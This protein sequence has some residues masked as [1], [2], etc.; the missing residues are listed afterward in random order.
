MGLETFEYVDDLVTTNPLGADQQSA[1]DDHLRGLKTTIK[2]TLKN[3]DGILVNWE[4]TAAPTANDDSGSGYVQGSLWFERDAGALYLCTDATATAAVW[5]K[6]YQFGTKTKSVSLRV[7][8]S[9]TACSTGDDQASIY[10][11]ADMDGWNLTDIEIFCD[12]AGT[13]G[14]MDV[15]IHNVD[16]ALDMLSTKAT[17][18]S[19]ETSSLTAATAPVINT[20][21]DHINTGDKIRVD[22]DAV[23]TTPASGLTVVLTFTEA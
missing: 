4:A 23:H 15:Q 22:V 2:N 9:A 20:S 11:P 12:T 3:V 14:T 7:T 5:R 16:N 10:I 6:V 1:G 8:D 13:T 21:N 19:A 17:I 18:D